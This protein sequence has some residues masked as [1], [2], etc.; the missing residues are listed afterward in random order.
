MRDKVEQ[1]E[2]RFVAKEERDRL[3]ELEKMKQNRK[4]LQMASDSQ[5]EEEVVP[6][7]Q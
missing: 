4:N 3:R 5:S 1:M 7:H 6:R 2:E